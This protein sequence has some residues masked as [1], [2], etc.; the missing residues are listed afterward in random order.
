[1]VDTALYRAAELINAELIPPLRQQLIGRRIASAD[2]KITPGTGTVRVNTVTEMNAG[3][4]AMKMPYDA[5]NRDIIKVT[6]AN[7]DI[8]YLFKDFIIERDEFNAWNDKGVA[9]DTAAAQSAAQ[10]VGIQED[11]LIFLGWKP[12]GVAY[13]INGF[14]NGA[15]NDYSTSKDFG[16]AGYAT[17]A[18]AGAIALIEADNGLA[19]AYNLILNPTQAAE[20]R[21]SRNTNGVLELPEVMQLLNMGKAT[22]PGEILSTTSMTAGTGLLTPVDPGRKFIELFIGID[23]S[24]ELGYSSINPD[25]GPIYGRVYERLYPHIKQANALCKLSAI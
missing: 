2:P 3:Q 8:P 20:L 4:I 18:V 13:N 14:Y 24:T 10:V 16:T 1:M 21:A 6:A 9:I 15:G 12:D 19:P 11:N 17:T 5:T 25:T 7:K 22:G 23:T